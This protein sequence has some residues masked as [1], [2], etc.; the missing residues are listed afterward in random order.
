MT[1]DPQRRRRASL[2]GVAG[3]VF[4]TLAIVV[5][6][7]VGVVTLRSSEEGTAVAP[8]ER[9]SQRFPST[10][11]AMVAVTSGERLSSV[12]VMVLDPIGIGG[13]VVTVPVNVD[14]T[15]G[16]GR[17]RTPL[18]R[19]AFE[20]GDP[21]PLADELVPLLG[22]QPT[23]LEVV[24]GD[25]L[26][27]LL[28]LAGQTSV[29]LPEDVVDVGGDT[30]VTVAPEGDDALRP[31]EVVA[32]LTSIDS[33]G[34]S[35]DHHDVDVAVWESIALAWSRRSGSVVVSRDEAGEPVAPDTFEEFV[36]RLRAGSVAVRDLAIDPRAAIV[37][38]NP[39][40]ADFVALDRRDS[41]LV[42]ASIAPERV[43]APNPTL[44][45]SIVAPFT[46]AQIAAAGEGLSTAGL[47]RDLIGE[48]T[49]LE[50]NVVSV[51]TRPGEGG[52]ASETVVVADDEEFVDPG[53]VPALIG[54]SS[55]RVAARDTEGSDVTLVL[56]T[57]F[58]AHRVELLAEEAASRADDDGAADFDVSGGDT[59]ETDETDGSGDDG[60]NDASGDGS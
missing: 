44:T 1:A 57:D 48:L 30:P 46:D 11:A 19:R 38:D 22:M 21:S 49:F 24:D 52:A 29:S 25:Q 7:V 50:V 43:L 27:E 31:D 59:D 35:Y 3:L 14:T 9:P 54:E 41:L 58:L 34:S 12:V 16:L 55:S 15:A 5:L 37:L 6:V 33:S 8:E 51:D 56:G 39:T 20:V 60:T 53:S 23:F 18:A 4:A 10:P 13:S 2:I 32:V 36:E 40:D 42:F 17:E 45:F 47:I 26:E 28:G